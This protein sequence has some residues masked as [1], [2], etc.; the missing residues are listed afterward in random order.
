MSVSPKGLVT[1]ADQE[2]NW[3]PSTRIDVYKQGGFYGDMRAHHRDKAPT[4]YDGPLCWLPREAD[5]SAGGQIHAPESGFGPL[6]GKLLHLSYGRCKMMILLTQEVDGIWQAGGIDS[7]VNFLA[8][9]MR[10]RFNALDG[11]LYVA[12]LNGWQTGAQRDGSIQRVRYT[13]KKFHTPTK[14][15]VVKNGIRLQFS[16]AL[17]RTTAED[18]RRY[19][20]DQWNYRWSAEYGSK[21]WSVANPDK[22]SIDPVTVK[23]ATLADD[24]RTIFLSIDGL[25]PVMQMRIEFNLNASDGTPV[26]GT[27][28]NT[29]HVVK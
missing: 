6:S 5:N 24:G 10:G 13:G 20:L 21:R 3:M 23:S 15:E 19:K 14:L 26:K 1:G 9:S 27:I 11:H 8:G 22:L 18:V 25:K 4:T 7:G 2:G 16:E 28:H 29:I 12:G 17:D